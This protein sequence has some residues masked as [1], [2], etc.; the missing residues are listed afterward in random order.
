MGEVKLIRCVGGGWRAAKA[1]DAEAMNALGCECSQDGI[2]EAREWFRKAAAAGNVDAMFNLGKSYEGTFGV[3]TKEQAAFWYQKAAEADDVEAMSEIGYAY[4]YGEGVK[5]DVQEAFRWTQKAAEAGNAFSMVE[6]GLFYAEGEVIEQDQEKAVEWY[7]QGI[8]AGSNRA[9]L[10]LGDA[11]EYGKGIGRDEKQAAFWYDQ[12][13]QKGTVAVH[14]AFAM[15]CLGYLYKK[16]R[17]LAKAEKEA[18]GWIW[19]AAERGDDVAMMEL[20]RAYESGGILQRNEK[21]AESWRKE[22]ADAGNREAIQIVY[23]DVET[24]PNEKITRWKRRQGIV[25]LEETVET[26][27]S[28]PNPSI[29]NY[30]ML[31]SG[32]IFGTGLRGAALRRAVRYTETDAGQRSA[33]KTGMRLA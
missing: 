4:K 11:Y 10:A 20:S 14:N 30:A 13:A 26:P 18:M 29:Y 32:E 8:K 16:D 25:K 33:K 23:G 15:R 28:S 24:E 21:K 6:V 5:Q 31:L 22:A 7:K 1:G 2:E 9:M 17:G 27:K 12:G 3:G 19:F